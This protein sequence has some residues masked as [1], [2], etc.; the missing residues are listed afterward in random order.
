PSFGLMLPPS[1]EQPV[2]PAL[3]GG[4]RALGVIVQDVRGAL[5][6][7]IGHSSLGPQRRRRV[8]PAPQDR[9]QA[10]EGLGQG[11]LFSTRSRLWARALR[12]SWSLSPEAVRGGWP[13]S[14]R[15]LRTALQEPR[16]TSASGSVRP[17][18]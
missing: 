6:P 7:A 18:H 13:S 4:L 16:T 11:P 9:L 3:H 10:P 14:G 5:P 12:R 1:P 2:Q 15:A 17:A 8:Q